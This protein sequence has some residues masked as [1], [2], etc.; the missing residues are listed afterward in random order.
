MPDSL[1][2]REKTER[3][4]EERRTAEIR[5]ADLYL[6]SGR[7]EAARPSLRAKY[8]ADPGS[9][10]RCAQL[11]LALIRAGRRVEAL[12]A[13]HQCAK[14]LAEEYGARP[15]DELQELLKTALGLQ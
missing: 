7:H 15:D 14:V 2:L 3:L 1:R 5:L 4:L 9:E 12:D 8:A 13:F 10:R 11:M 6:A